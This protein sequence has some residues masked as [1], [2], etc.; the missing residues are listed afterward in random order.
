MDRPVSVDRIVILSA[1]VLLDE[2][3][4][5]VSEDVGNRAYLLGGFFADLQNELFL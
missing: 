3:A 5:V 4:S 2:V 1:V